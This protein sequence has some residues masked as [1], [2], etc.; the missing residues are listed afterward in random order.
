MS[1]SSIRSIASHLP[2]LSASRRVRRFVERDG[3]LVTTT[4]K[5][6]AAWTSGRERRSA[7]TPQELADIEELK[8]GGDPGQLILTGPPWDADE[9]GEPCLMG[10]EEYLRGLLDKAT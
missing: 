2:P 5:P 4:G 8:R 3:H 7:F 6:F 1:P 10:F 9:L